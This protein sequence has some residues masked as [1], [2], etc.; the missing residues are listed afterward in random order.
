MVVSCGTL[1]RAVV[2][3]ERY[4][5]PQGKLVTQVVEGSILPFNNPSMNL[6]LAV[7]CFRSVRDEVILMK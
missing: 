3:V 6:I 5:V 1:K 2:R 7:Q 4:K